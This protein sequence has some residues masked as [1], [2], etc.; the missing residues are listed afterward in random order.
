VLPVWNLRDIG[1]DAVIRQLCLEPVGVVKPIDRHRD[2]AS[3]LVVSSNAALA[4]GALRLPPSS[5]SPMATPIASAPADATD[6]TL[7]R[8][9][10]RARAGRA[11][12]CSAF[13][14]ASTDF[15]SPSSRSSRCEGQFRLLVVR[16][17][18]RRPS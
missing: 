18:G 9:H 4:D 14:W 16:P 6:T 12:D 17:S 1:L 5:G 10:S 2:R 7:P 8:R 15:S 13:R 3:S 11:A